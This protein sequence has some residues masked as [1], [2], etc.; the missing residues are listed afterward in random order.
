M[1]ELVRRLD[2]EYG[3]KLTEEE[4]DLIAAQAEEADR[5]FQLLYKV[6]LTDVMPVMKIDK[7]V[8]KRKGRK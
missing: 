7:R 4:I 5:L 3:C 8:D 6:D 1:K 2:A